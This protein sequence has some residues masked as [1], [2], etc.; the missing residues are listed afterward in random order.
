[1][2]LEDLSV[3]GVGW[4]CPDMFLE[5]SEEPSLRSGKGNGGEP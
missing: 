1:M 4:G 3:L 5:G 2:L